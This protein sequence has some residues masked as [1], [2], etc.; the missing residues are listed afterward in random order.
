MVSIKIG[1][2]AVASEFMWI[3]EPL[4]SFMDWHVQTNFMNP[5]VRLQDKVI[6]VAYKKPYFDKRR[7]PSEIHFYV[8]YFSLEIIIL[9]LETTSSKKEHEL[10]NFVLLYTNPKG[11]IHQTLK[12]FLPWVNISSHNVFAYKIG[13]TCRLKLFFL[14]PSIHSSDLLF[15]AAI[16]YLKL[17]NFWVW[18]VKHYLPN[19]RNI[20][21]P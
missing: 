14:C 2:C 3:S 7:Q 20:T 1:S 8:W 19:I 13:V 16:W 17:Y 5:K 21:T 11:P 12:S 15:A 6:K 10:F 18:V 4:V 9:T